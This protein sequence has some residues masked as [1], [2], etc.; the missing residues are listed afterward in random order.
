MPT[1]A[2]R[3]PTSL[4]LLIK[5]YYSLTKPGVLYGNVITGVAGFLLAAG[6][7]RTFDVELFVATILG[8]TF[9]IASACAINNV[10]DRDIDAKMARTKQRAVASGVI[11]PLPAS[12]F[13]TTLAVIGFVMLAVS[14]NW[15][16]VAVGAAGYVTYVWLYGAT[17]KRRSIHG[18]LV[19]SI[20]G[21]MPILAGYVAVSERIDAAAVLVFLM[22]FFW[23]F[24]EFYSIAIYRLKEYRAANIPVMPIVVGVKNTR[25]QIFLYTVAFVVSSLLI[26]FF[27]F[28][29]WLYFAVMAIAG[30]WWIKLA[31]AG[32]K[33]NDSDA[34]ARRMFHFSLNVLLLLSLMLAIGP[35]LP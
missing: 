8:M 23:Q 3:R 24:P 26:T 6:N 22:L 5:R 33:T 13:A 35:W 2:A 21:A 16:V 17:S 18:T 20:S 11:N 28:T 27:G 31:A 10:L 34:W 1:I 12:I 19:G 15:L 7:F 30:A 14:T 9:V 32:L 29:G 4:N 25:V